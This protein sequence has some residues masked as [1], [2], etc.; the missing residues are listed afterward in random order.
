MSGHSWGRK[1]TV[2]GITGTVTLCKYST[3]TDTSD[4]MKVQPPMNTT[5]MSMTRFPYWEQCVNTHT[6]PAAFLIAVLIN[7]PHV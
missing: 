1:G 2:G 5:Y 3:H 7:L 4:L 6:H